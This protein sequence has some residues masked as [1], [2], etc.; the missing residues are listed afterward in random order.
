MRNS[1]LALA[2][3]AP[4][5]ASPAAAQQPS[6]TSLTVESIFKRGDFRSA[7][8]PNVHW[9]KDGKSYLDT[10]PNAGGGADIVRV[11]LT[12][13]AERVI[14]DAKSIVD[15]TGKRIDIED[16]TLS[17]DESKALLFHGSVRV[18]RQ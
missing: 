1:L 6:D 5:P 2:L 18:W 12:T 8:L 9:L 4:L 11:D 13:G 7:Q 10:R 17:D 16:I 3:L 15:A 14:A